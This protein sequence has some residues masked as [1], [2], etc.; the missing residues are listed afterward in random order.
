[1]WRKPRAHSIC[2][3]KWSEMASPQA[4]PSLQCSLGCTS[5]AAFQGCISHFLFPL[6]KSQLLGDQS[7]SCQGACRK[8]FGHLCL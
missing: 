1:M 7:L 8:G 6:L 4:H 2:F 5:P 3:A